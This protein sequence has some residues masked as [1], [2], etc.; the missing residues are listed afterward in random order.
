MSHSRFMMLA[1]LFQGGL[2]LSGI[3]IAHWL[4]ISLNMH[5]STTSIV[6]GVLATLPMLVFLWWVLLT[7]WKPLRDLREILVE[8]LGPLLA[9][10]SLVDLIYLSIL[11][12]VSEEILFRGAI[13]NGLL[14]LG[15]WPA[16]IL[17]NLIFGICHAASFTYF[18]YA[19]AAGFYLTAVAGISPQNLLPAILTHSLYDFVALRVVQQRAISFKMNRSEEEDQQSHGETPSIGQPSDEDFSE[20]S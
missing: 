18:L 3:V 15:L 1:T 14:G 7:T 8:Q 4:G 20:I 11:A 19:L 6:R 9:R 2:L 17:T 13:Q 12:G 5:W 16:L 10:C